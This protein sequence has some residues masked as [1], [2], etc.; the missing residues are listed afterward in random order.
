MWVMMGSKDTRAIERPTSKDYIE[1]LFND[2]FEICGDRLSGDDPAIIAG[3]CRFNGKSIKV[4]GHQKGKKSFEEA[5]YYN[6]GMPA[7]QGYRKAC[8]A[9]KRAEKFNRPVICFIDTIGA[10]CR[11]EAE[12]YGQSIA[13]AKMLR[14]MS[15]LAVPILSIVIS[16]GASGGAL[17]LGVGNEVWM[18]ENAIYSIVTP[19]A[20]ASIRWKDN[21]K[22]QEAV[23]EMKL[24]SKDLIEEGIIDKIIPEMEQLTRESMEDYLDV[25]PKCFYSSGAAA[26]CSKCEDLSEVVN[27]KGEFYTLL[28]N[29]GGIDFSLFSNEDFL[30]V[31][32]PTIKVDLILVSKY[33]DRYIRKIKC[34][35]VLM[36][37]EEDKCDISQWDIY[38]G[39]KINIVYFKGNHFFIE[40]NINE[41]VKMLESGDDDEI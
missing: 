1:H 13:I 35:I 24:L 11:R 8:R 41:I 15:V 31:F 32:L 40:E 4:I 19:E 5:L 7:P 9:I 3:I 12:E 2:F 6:C 36:E 39:S 14:D 29:Y 33:T 28:T 30:E 16:E 26:P 21:N 27:N 25:Y 34:L 18:L 17:A 37:G 23:E 22:V 10:D 20:Y 38:A